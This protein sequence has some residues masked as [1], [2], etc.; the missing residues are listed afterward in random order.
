MTAKAWIPNRL[1]NEVQAGIYQYLALRG[2]CFWWRQNSG[3]FS[4]R[5]GAFIRAGKKG[6]GDIL[7]CQAPTGRMVAIEVKRSKGGTVGPKQREFRDQLT[8]H[9][10]LYIVA[11]SIDD[12]R[13]TLGEPKV[14]IPCPFSG[15]IYPK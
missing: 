4:P 12:V 5:P 6:A 13:A 14:R 3:V 7:C 11:R 15:R 10:G 8:A 9:G 1:E 2:D